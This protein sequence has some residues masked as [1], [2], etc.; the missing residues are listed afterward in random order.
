MTQQAFTPDEC[1]YLINYLENAKY[2]ECFHLKVTI[3]L[4]FKKRKLN[5]YKVKICIKELILESAQNVLFFLDYVF[6][7]KEDLKWNN[8]TFTWH[9]N[10]QP[11]LKNAE[12]KLLKEKDTWIYKLRDKRGKL[13]IRLSECLNRVKE[14]RL[15]DRISE[16]EDINRDLKEITVEL[17]QFYKEVHIQFF[18]FFF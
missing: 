2:V 11:I 15:R 8:Y 3:K 7:S 9:D 18:F 1:V 14:F 12:I 4:N 5:H 13:S 6:F 16:A 10:I 17:D